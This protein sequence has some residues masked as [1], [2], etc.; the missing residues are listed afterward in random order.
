MTKSI[1]NQPIIVVGMARSGTTLIANILGYS[2]EL[3][4]IVEPHA[5][6]RTGNFQFFNDQ[7]Y[8][9]EQKNIKR[10]R[11]K[12][13]NIASE[14][15]LVEKSP[16]NSLRSDLVY[17]TFPDAKII[18]LERDPVR[19]IYSNY[20]RSLTQDSFK[21]SI[22]LKKYFIKTG[23]SDLP[24][25]ISN[26]GIFTQLSIKDIPYFIIYIIRM[27]WFRNISN[28][29]PFG[30]K[31]RNFYNI[32]KKKGLLYYHVKVYYESMKEK[33]KYKQLYKSNMSIFQL[34]DIMQNKNEIKR[35]FKELGISFNQHKINL[36]YNNIDKRR[37]HNACQV[38]KLD[39]EILDVLN[40]CHD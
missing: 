15:R 8:N 13:L 14:K 36:I 29:L 16:I 27:F 33:K 11:N 25:A 39:E 5:L 4:I 21:L 3:K 6:W 34:E 7:D 12:L 26:V 28:L 1:N 35:L 31:I 9:L 24:N 30:P 22:I 23:T 19:L 18:Y 2:Q 20:Q 17:A 40:N 10:I 32:V 38:H 37:I